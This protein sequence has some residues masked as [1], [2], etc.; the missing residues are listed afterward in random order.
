MKHNTVTVKAATEQLGLSRVR[1]LGL[2]KQGKLVG[3]KST[4]DGTS[5]PQVLLDRKSVESYTPSRSTGQRSM[6]VKLPSEDLDKIEAICQEHGWTLKSKNN[7]SS[8]RVV[9]VEEIEEEEV[10]QIET[11]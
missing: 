11:A 10:E 1:V 3:T 5:I 4:T 9:E 8:K 7:G 6:I 2:Y